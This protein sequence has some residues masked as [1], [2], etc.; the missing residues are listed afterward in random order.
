MGSKFL[1]NH[2]DHLLDRHQLLLLAPMFYI[3]V[4]NQADALKD[5][6]FNDDITWGFKNYYSII[7]PTTKGVEKVIELVN[8]LIV[9]EL[10]GILGSKANRLCY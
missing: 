9:S 3:E 5:Q 8:T 7:K 10:V 6:P 1:F 2:S 4:I